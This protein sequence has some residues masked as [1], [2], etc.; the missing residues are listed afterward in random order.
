MLN[1]SD[2]ATP[3][4]VQTEEESNLSDQARRGIEND[5]ESR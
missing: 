4:G 1:L 3:G 2:Q 5:T